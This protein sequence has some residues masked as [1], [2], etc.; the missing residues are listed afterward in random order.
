MIETAYA[1]AVEQTNSG[2]PQFDPGPF[3]SQIFWAVASFGV[4]LFLL[5]RYVLPIINETLDKRAAS[6]KDEVEQAEQ[7]RKDAERVVAEYQQQLASIHEEAAVIL[8]ESRKD[9]IEYRKKTMREMDA[10][11]KKKK[12]IFSAELDFAKRQAL[13]EVRGVAVDLTMQATEKLVARHVDADEAG[14]MVES[15]IEELRTLSN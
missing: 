12:E 10:E 15:S 1:A 6:I 2:L 11:L 8:E 3:A 4:L 5:N 9:A 14:R 7:L 13:K